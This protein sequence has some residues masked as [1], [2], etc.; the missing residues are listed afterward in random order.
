MA[1]VNGCLYWIKNTWQFTI[2][3]FVFENVHKMFLKNHMELI[4][5]WIC[6]KD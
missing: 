5:Y 3:P 2:F 6:L 1:D 4:F